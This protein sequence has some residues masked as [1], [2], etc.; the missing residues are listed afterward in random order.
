M[1][2]DFVKSDGG[3]DKSKQ[4]GYDIEYSNPQADTPAHTAKP[5][6]GNLLGFFHK[7]EPN[8]YSKP[9]PK[10]P[11]V[12]TPGQAV[13]A[14]APTSTVRAIHQL[15]Q[16]PNRQ[17]TQPISTVPTVSQQPKTAA[18][19]ERRIPPAPPPPVH[20]A[21]AVRANSLP[22]PSLPSVPTTQP[23]PT[24]PPT[25]PVR[26][27]PTSQA[28]P[29][30]PAAPITAAAHHATSVGQIIAQNVS[31]MGGQS[32]NP[33]APHPS[34][35]SLNLLPNAMYKPLHQ[36][37]AVFR[38]FRTA[39]LT[40]MAGTVLYLAMVCYQ[41]FFVWQT[42]T[43]LTELR[44]LDATI[45]SYRTLQNDINSTSDTLLAIQ[46]LLDEHIYWTQW[47]AFLEQY[48]LPTVYYTNFSG[49]D[50][51]AMNL[52][53]IAPDYNTIAQQITVFQDRTEVQSVTVSTATAVTSGNVHFTIS[54]Q[55]DPKIVRYGQ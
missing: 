41:A 8:P 12:Q 30:V 28:I 50:T 45:L 20:T 47:F 3:K 55:M 16:R 52:D 35:V 40:V 31:G 21:P 34:L 54:L 27:T 9:I 53:A 13:S 43:V 46:Q 2:A 48:T 6:H 38:L 19:P 7:A 10:Q 33:A 17:D 4:S 39:T 24:P 14:V 42:H 22:I 36:A 1:A 49:S 15:P 26:T 44:T 11:T 5:K 25:S 18:L 29:A 23:I 32:T 51:G 37:S